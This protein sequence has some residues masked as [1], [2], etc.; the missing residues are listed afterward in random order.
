MMNFTGSHPPR[1]KYIITAFCCLLVISL[2]L[3]GCLEQVQSSRVPSGALSNFLLH[4][5]Q[6]ELDDARA[7]MAPGLVTPSAALDQSIKGASARVR[8]YEIEG[9]KATSVDL[10]NGE[11]QE[12]ISARVRPK[13]PAGQPTPSPNSGWQQ[14]DVITAR[15]VM[16]G[17]GWRILNFELK[18]CD[19]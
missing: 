1:L 5:K 2:A 10:G 18:C 19:K 8:R 17:P 3:S 6:G 4:L 13:T 16:R 11:L 7:Y 12:T 15:I 9:Q 14:T